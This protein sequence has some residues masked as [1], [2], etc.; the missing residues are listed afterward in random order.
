MKILIYGDYYKWKS[1]FAREIKDVLPHLKKGNDVRQVALGYNGY[2]IDKDMIVYHTKTPEVKNHYAQEVLHYA[3]DDFKPD[4]VLTVQDF[5]IL[6]KISF[7]LAHPGKFKWV[8]WG[9]CIEGQTEILMADGSTKTIKE[10]V[11][12]K[13]KD[14]IRCYDKKN[15]RY[16]KSKIINWYKNKATK[17]DWYRV[18]FNNSTDKSCLT[19]TGDHPLLTNF[20]WMKVKDIY[21]DILH[22]ELLI[23]YDKCLT[24][25][26]KQVLLGMFIGDGWVENNGSRFCFAH[27]EPQKNYLLN[28]AK[29]LDA[30]IKISLPGK[31]SFVKKGNIYTA[32]LSLKRTCPEIIN[33]FNKKHKASKELFNKMNEIGLAFWYM[34]D[35]C[36]RKSK[37]NLNWFRPEFATNSFSKEE[38]NN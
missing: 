2:P 11:D 30:H 21:N 18:Y 6:P 32:R 28:T 3:L 9:T 5:W 24:N 22:H 29:K 33:L 10:I 35:G 17:E 23:R 37:Q 1:G 31:S 15:D 38:L 12:N 13:I 36:L 19:V 26:G 20:G 7:T 8:H 16:T 27:T 4:I 14:E 34:D 25:E